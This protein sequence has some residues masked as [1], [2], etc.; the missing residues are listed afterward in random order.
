MRKI[1]LTLLMLLIGTLGFAQNPLLLKDVY[2]GAT[3]SGIQQI[4]K[5]SNYTFFNAMDGSSADRG[6]YRTDGTPGGTIKLNLTYPNYISTKAD[7][8]TALGDKVIFAGNNSANFGEIWASDGT[9]AG[10]VVI[11]RFQPTLGSGAV[12]D[13]AR[14][15][16]VVLYAVVDNNNH[17]LL[18]KTDGTIAGTSL[19]YEF[20]NFTLPPDAALFKEI[21]NILYFNIFDAEGTGFDQ[22][23]RSDGTPGG[24]YMVYNFGADHYVASSYMPAGNNFYLMLVLPG[25]GNELWKSDGTAAGTQAVKVIGTTGNNNYPPNAAI[26]S[27]LYFAGLDG[28][29]KELWKTD[30]TNAG[31]VMVADIN[32]GT[33]SSNPANLTLLNNQIYF[34]ASTATEGTELWKFDGTNTT[35]VKDI[36]TGTANSSPGSFAVSN[37]SIV[38]RA[39]T[40]NEGSELW[41]TDGTAANTLLVANINPGAAGSLPNQMTAGNPVYF[42]ANNGVDGAEIFKFDNGS[43]LVVNLDTSINVKCFEGNTGSINI[44]VTGGALPYT[45]NWSRNGA[46]GYSTQEDPA[47]L[48][49]GTYD[50]MLTDANAATASLTGIVITEPAMLAATATGVSTSCVNSASV[51]AT[52]GTGSYTYLWSNGAT[53][54]SISNIP[55]GTYSVTIT[56]ENGCSVIASCTVTGSAA[57]NPSIAIV[58]VSCFGGAD[59]NLTITNVNGV[60]PY[61]Y[62]VDG[63]SFQS[64]NVFSGL[65][66]G[67]YT[68]TVKDAL[69]CTGFKTKIITQP[70][71][72]LIT[73]NNV[74]PT[75]YGANN[76]SINISAAGGSPGFTYSW[77]GPNGFT[78]TSSNINNLATGSYTLT[79]TDKKGCTAQLTAMVPTSAQ[80]NVDSTVTN[81]TCKGAANGSIAVNVTGGSGSGFIYQWNTGATTSS[82][83]NL[84][85]GNYSLI[86]TDIGS[87]CTITK[88]YSITQPA[89]ALNM[90]TSKTNVAGCNSLGTITVSGSGGTAPY[91]YSMDGTTFGNSGSF[92]GLYQNNYTVYVKDANGCI[93]SAAVAITDN[94]TDEYENNNS[95]NKAAAITLGSVVNGRL[96]VA[97]DAAD[98]FRFVTPAGTGTYTL[99]LTHPSTNFTFNLYTA[100]NNTPALISSGT[101]ATS[102]TYELN[103]NTTYYISVTGG[104]SYTCYNL[105]V[106]ASPV[107]TKTNTNTNGAAKTS[108]L[109]E[110]ANAIEV[111]TLTAIAYP[112]PHQGVVSLQISSPEKGFAKIEFFSA[113][114]QK[115]MVKN[116]GVQKGERNIVP[117]NIT[118]RGTVFYRIQIGK[119]TA[120]GKIIGT[121]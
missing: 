6:L 118:Q 2:P 29:G 90:S 81:I 67:S 23:W 77:S 10:T 88:S 57:F 39:A 93:K 43:T 61:E 56:D 13:M 40:L 51:S 97:G 31:T 42:T 87:S 102:K 16:S 20:S 37:N 94:G 4:V 14:L 73:L 115:L 71:Q 33:N 114:G 113:N 52:G 98:W 89:S 12:Q 60:A 48:I 117:I 119:Y 109:T 68:I 64:S 63:I 8:L 30:G 70:T 91:Q 78:A 54:D 45:F 72:I 50:L 108:N 100:G 103:G 62:S 83:T 80:V 53:T 41:I 19:V 96:A 49:A 85:K 28:N 84:G 15:G 27:T 104:L 9:Q 46:A 66:A 26:G 17:T 74:Q 22:L 34:S 21:N 24:T 82:I 76:G 59:G 32:P 25:A 5:T 47:N 44:T 58:N 3:G 79:V 35:L 107:F 112:N 75:C 105:M 18:K 111:E 55:S 1:Q 11:E 7:K 120:S 36:N 38:F 92:T 99:S 95:K 65:S 86:I 121:N 116:V 106:I 110:T 101:T 69:G